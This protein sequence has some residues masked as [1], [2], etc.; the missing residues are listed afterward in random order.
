[1]ADAYVTY[2]FNS[3]VLTNFIICFQLVFNMWSNSLKTSLF[4]FLIEVFLKKGLGELE[5]KSSPQK[6]NWNRDLNQ[7]L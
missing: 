6:K 7:M 1:M 2:N 4:F 3:R 5:E